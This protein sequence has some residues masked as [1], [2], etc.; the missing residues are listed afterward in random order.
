RIDAQYRY[1]YN[2]KAR[3]ALDRNYAGNSANYITLGLFAQKS[4]GILSGMKDNWSVNPDWLPAVSAAWGIQRLY[5]GRWL[6]NAELGVNYW[7]AQLNQ[8]G[9]HFAPRINFS[10]SYLLFRKHK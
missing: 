6:L 3:K 7:F 5:G 9:N 2:F 1:Y 10:F 4:L 8:N